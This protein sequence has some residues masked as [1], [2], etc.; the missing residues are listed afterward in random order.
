VADIEV[1]NVVA[2]APDVDTSR[3]NTDNNIAAEGA[4]ASEEEA[5]S[6]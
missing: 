1:C 2:A 4:E 6:N 3:A 5:I